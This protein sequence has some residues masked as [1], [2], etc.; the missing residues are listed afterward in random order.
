MNIVANS[1]ADIIFK[2]IT[3]GF[4]N[5]KIAEWDKWYFE[6]FQ[7]QHWKEKWN[8]L[9][10]LYT[11]LLAIIYD[12]HMTIKSSL[13]LHKHVKSTSCFAQVEHFSGFLTFEKATIFDGANYTI[14]H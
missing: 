10:T 12:E 8:V 6:N 5:V 3:D 13:E 4:F 7:W 9:K 14:F 1:D 11:K 2:I